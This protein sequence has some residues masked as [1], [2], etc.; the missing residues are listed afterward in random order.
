MVYTYVLRY[1]S[2]GCIMNLTRAVLQLRPLSST[3]YHR[4][5]L[6]LLSHLTSAPDPTGGFSAYQSRFALLRQ[7]NSVS[8]RPS[9]YTIAIVSTGEDK[10]VALGTLILEHKFIRDLGSVGHIEDIVVDPT[11][12][13][14][15]L[16]KRV[17]EALTGIAEK[18]GA[19]KVILDCNKDNIGRDHHCFSTATRT[20]KTV[21]TAFY[22][23][24]GYT[25][26]VRFFQL[27]PRSFSPC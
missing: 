4:G 8:P 3:D 2:P 17:I 7:I 22:E 21:A 18:V 23:K 10:I 20:D 16:G 13:G 6:A 19:Y 15:S 5:H 27:S 26:K 11:V 25:H 12:R 9:Y 14:K 1:R 24:C